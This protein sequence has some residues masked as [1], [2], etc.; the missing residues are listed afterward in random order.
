MIAVIQC[1]ASKRSGAGHL[2]SANGK[3]VVFVAEPQAAPPNSVCVY[4]R[5]DDS[6]NNGLTWRETLQKYNDNPGKN[7]LG[8]CR[9]YKLYKKAIYERLV[10]RLGVQRVYILSAGWGLIR[11]DFLTP[12]YDI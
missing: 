10:D 12:Y 2:L 3:R 5:P 7:S 1:S 9:A 11:A 6:S 8:L 4:A